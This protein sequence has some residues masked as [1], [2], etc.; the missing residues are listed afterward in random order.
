MD[1]KVVGIVGSYRKGGI[2]DN[3]VSSVLDGAQECGAE[4]KKIYL[5]DKHIEFCANCRTCT[6]E[7]GDRGNAYMMTIWK[8]Y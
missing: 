2:I 3:A 5:L 1:Q 7:E 8:R 6:Q 4:T